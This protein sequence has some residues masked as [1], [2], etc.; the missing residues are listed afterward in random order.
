MLVSIYIK[1]TY[2]DYNHS[3]T[4][5]QTF[6]INPEASPDRKENLN[7]QHTNS[8]LFLMDSILKISVSSSGTSGTTSPEK[9][10]GHHKMITCQSGERKMKK[11]RA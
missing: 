3:N 1:N 10:C 8:M 6:H 7:R 4:M 5:S 9:K 2:K 11:R